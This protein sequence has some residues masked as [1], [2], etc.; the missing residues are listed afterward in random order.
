MKPSVISFFALLLLLTACLPLS[1]NSAQGVINL[2]KSPAFAL[3][4]NKA[5]DCGLKNKLTLNP[6]N[7]PAVADIALYY[8]ASPTGDQKPVYQI[9]S[10]D[11]SI[12]TNQKEQQPL[13]KEEAANLFLGIYDETLQVWVFPGED[14]IQRSFEQ[15]LLNGHRV[16]PNTRV[17]LTT[18]K[19]IQ[20][21]LGSEPSIG[22]L[23]SELVPP[24]MKTL[25]VTENIPLLAVSPQAPSG[26][27]ALFTQCL[28]K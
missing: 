15:F 13:S 23:P 10:S 20:G 6:I 18:E 9:G 1:A 12:I 16:S 3:W 8:G 5:E 2:Y 21:L 7:D 19:M 25:F 24:T 28:Q 22:F 26:D 27:L 17:A 11:L 14:D 4:Y